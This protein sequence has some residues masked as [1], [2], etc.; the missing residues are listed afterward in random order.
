MK[1]LNGGK[2]EFEITLNADELGALC[3]CM[4]EACGAIS[5]SDAG[6]AMS[7]RMEKVE[8]MRRELSD[9]IPGEPI[10]L[11]GPRLTFP[12]MRPAHSRETWE[13]PLMKVVGG[14]EAA[15]EMLLNEGAL[16]MICLCMSE[17]CSRFAPPDFEER[18]GPRKEAVI[19]MLDVLLRSDWEEGE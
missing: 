1:I 10:Q 9:L 14:G 12:F 17:V 6:A 8:A 5:A 11:N 15:F 3:N 13:R 2:G 7:A 19:H 18:I 16:S 4:A